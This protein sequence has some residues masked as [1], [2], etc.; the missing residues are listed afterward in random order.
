VNDML[1]ELPPRIA[2][3]I[4][5]ADE[6]WPGFGG[7]WLWRGTLSRGYGRVKVGGRDRGTHCVVY[8]MLIGPIPDGL[9]LD[10]VCDRKNCVN[11]AHL[12]PVSHAENIRRSKWRSFKVG[13]DKKLYMRRYRAENREALRAGSRE[14]VRRYRAKNRQEVNAR[15]RDRYHAARLMER[16]K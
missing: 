11:P 14:R 3:K 16:Y 10:H 7:C 2:A 4:E 8:E 1:G 5:I 9:E 6:I 12:D 13:V 15:Q